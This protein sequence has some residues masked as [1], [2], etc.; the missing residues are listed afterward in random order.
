MADGL[1]VRIKVIRIAEMEQTIVRLYEGRIRETP[2]LAGIELNGIP[3]WPSLA[4]VVGDI[5]AK[6]IPAIV[7]IIEQHRP[8]A[9]PQRKRI[10][11]RPAWQRCLVCHGP[12]LSSIV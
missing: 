4:L 5:Q 8:A 9:I 12:A 6:P 2:L 1:F 3:K 7:D 11:T 10:D